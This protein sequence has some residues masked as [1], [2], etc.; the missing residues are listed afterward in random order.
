MV[1]MAYIFSLLLLFAGCEKEK[2][3]LSEDASDVFYVKNDGSSMRVL[4]EGN[5]LSKVFVLIVHGGPG[6]SSFVYQTDYIRNNLED[7]ITMVYWDQRNAGASQGN[8]NG[9]EL[10]LDQMIDDLKKVIEVLKYRYGQ[11]ISIYL[12]GH[13]FGGLITTGFVTRPEYQNMIR[14]LINMDA[15][16]D[17]PLNDKLTRDMLL[18]V[19]AVQ[20]AQN[21]NIDEWNDIIRYCLLHPGHTTIHESLDLEHYATKAE[22]YIDSV[23]QVNIPNL[24]LEKAIPEKYPLTSI[25]VN[26][27]YSQNSALIKEISTVQFSPVL[28]K[29]TLPVLLLWGKYDFICPLTLGEDFLNHISSSEKKIVVSPVSGHNL[30]LQ[31][32]KLFC[33]EVFNFV[34]QN[35]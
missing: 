6:E 7:K 23:R 2:I 27:L 10:H 25:L 11:D 17:Y 30:F 19:G 4:V 32:E 15:S 14:G 5:T 16:H 1:R 31:D 26:L 24:I 29:I 33:D 3:T 34:T 18:S 21:K 8:L 22:D 35:Q 13:S 9:D 12:L 28:N 20:V